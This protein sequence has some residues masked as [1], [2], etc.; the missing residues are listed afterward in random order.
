M[1]ELKTYEDVNIVLNCY[2]NK[3]LIMQEIAMVSLMSS[4]G[5]G[6]KDIR[7]LNYFD[8]LYSVSEYLEKTEICPLCFDEVYSNL[9]CRDD[10]I[11]RWELYNNKRNF[12]YTTFST[13]EAT[14][15]ILDWLYIKN[16]GNICG[17]DPIFTGPDGKKITMEYIEFIFEE[18]E[19]NSGIHIKAIDLRK[20]FSKTMRDNNLPEYIL[21]YFLGLTPN[22]YPENISSDKIFKIQYRLKGG[23][24]LI[25]NQSTVKIPIEDYYTLLNN[26]ETVELLSDW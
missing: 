23:S 10:V 13:A 5:M 26:I 7:E 25:L 12:F 15:A 1:R 14:H 21:N 20:L 4:N 22:P 6:I 8:F 11:G 9:R 17:Y 18:M 19:N 2:G 16:D 3:E 24:E